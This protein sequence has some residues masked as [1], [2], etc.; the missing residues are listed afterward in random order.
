MI[1]KRYLQLKETTIY[2]HIPYRFS[3]TNHMSYGPSCRFIVP[4]FFSPFLGPASLWA[5]GRK[6]F[7]QAGAKWQQKMRKNMEEHGR[8]KIDKIT[9]DL[10]WLKGWTV[11]DTARIT[12]QL[13]SCVH[14][15]HHLHH[16]LY[17]RH[18]CHCHRMSSSI[19]TVCRA[20]TLGTMRSMVVFRLAHQPRTNASTYWDPVGENAAAGPWCRNPD[21]VL[22]P[23]HCMTF[24]C[25]SSRH[26][27][28]AMQRIPTVSQRQRCGIV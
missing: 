21:L 6:G 26:L 8:T 20:I 10:G 28:L 19:I 13:K 16:D 4:P 22:S 3:T 11:D 18:H 17:H 5:V 27:L 2:I 15:G 12:Y 1:S 7:N 9:W 23:L 24:C 25:V 14:Q